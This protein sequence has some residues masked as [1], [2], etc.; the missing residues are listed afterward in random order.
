MNTRALIE[1]NGEWNYETY[2]AKIKTTTPTKYFIFL[3]RP[4]LGKLGKK[5]W[6]HFHTPYSICEE[7]WKIDLLPLPAYKLARYIYI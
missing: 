6:K 1:R 2:H 4:C 3:C 7:Y 5:Q